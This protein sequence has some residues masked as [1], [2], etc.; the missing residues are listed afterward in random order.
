MGLKQ[1]QLVRANRRPPIHLAEG[2]GEPI[3]IPFGGLQT[4]NR[5]YR[6]IRLPAGLELNG[7]AASAVAPKHGCGLQKALNRKFAG[8]ST[9]AHVHKPFKCFHESRHLGILE[10]P[11]FDIPKWSSWG[12]LASECALVS[13]KNFFSN[14]FPRH[15]EANPAA[16]RQRGVG[17]WAKTHSDQG[18]PA[19]IKQSRVAV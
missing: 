1:Q 9:P 17:V 16:R 12:G 19:G 15:V 10:K 2:V 8:L 13:P 11:M 3:Q 6:F 5:L 4:S 7:A 14:F 18:Q